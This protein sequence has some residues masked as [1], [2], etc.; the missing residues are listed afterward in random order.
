MNALPKTHTETL[1]I[2]ATRQRHP[3]PGY[4]LTLLPFNPTEGTN[5]GGYILLGSAEVT[6]D[7]PA[8]NPLQAEVAALEKARDQILGEARQKAATINQQI[9]QLLC[10][11]HQV[12]P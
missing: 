2:C 5:Y 4:Q 11:E 6:V 10:I 3:A 7:I 8:C 12:Q 9:Q 1:F